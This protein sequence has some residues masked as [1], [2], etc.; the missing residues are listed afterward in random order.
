M[1]T[2]TGHEAAQR[3][4]RRAIGVGWCER[5]AAA[6]CARGAIGDTTGLH[7]GGGL[8]CSRAGWSVIAAGDH[9]GNGF[10]GGGTVAV[11][12]P[13]GVGECEALTHCQVVERFTAGVERPAEA[14]AGLCVGEDVGGAQSEHCQQLAVVRAERAARASRGAGGDHRHHTGCGG[15]GAIQV[16]H[17]QRAAGGQS[18]VGFRQRGRIAVAAGHRDRGPIVGSG[19]RDRHRGVRT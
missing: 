10:V 3:E 17:R 13:H 14:V 15:I 18:G 9:H 8:G 16:A 5:D 19:D 6:G 11:A 2:P 12:H 4:R 1:E 7:Q